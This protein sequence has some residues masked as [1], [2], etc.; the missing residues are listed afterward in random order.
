MWTETAGIDVEVLLKSAH[1][2]R[3]ID[4]TRLF[5]DQKRSSKVLTR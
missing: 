4:A 5:V 2:Q 3:I 1:G